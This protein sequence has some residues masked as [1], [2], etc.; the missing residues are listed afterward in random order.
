MKNLITFIKNNSFFLVPYIAVSF[1]LVILI[2]TNS[3]AELHI[4]CNEHHNTFF[5][6]FF[7]NI[8]RL[9]NG[10]VIAILI[11]ILLFVKFKYAIIAGIGNISAIAVTQIIKRFIIS[12]NP[13]PLKFFSDFSD[14]AYNLYIV[15][16]TE[17]TNWYSFPSGHTTTAFAMFLFLSVIS[18]NKILKFIFF[19][20][21]SLT[22]YSR[23]YLSFHF[24]EDITGGAFIGC[25]FM[26]IVFLI[27]ENKNKI[28]FDKKINLKIKNS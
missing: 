5:D 7:K 11:I 28:W 8:T 20:I 9:G 24:I 14:T 18:K 1:F 13:R 27:F 19:I 6:F 3:K 21:A 17:P 22:A 16:G 4:A 15:P 26:T 12:K 10:L 25:F 23:V 2:F